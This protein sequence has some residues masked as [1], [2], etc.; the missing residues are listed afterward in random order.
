MITCVHRNCL[1]EVSS[2]LGFINWHI[3]KVIK[4][5]K[6]Q[7]KEKEKKKKIKLYQNENHCKREREKK[8]KMLTAMLWLYTQKSLCSILSII[9]NHEPPQHNG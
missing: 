6:K 2:W 1:S 8:K 9:P 5:T 4:I 7:N 3:N